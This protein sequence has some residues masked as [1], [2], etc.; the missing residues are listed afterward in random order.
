MS[1]GCAWV[2]MADT[3]MVDAILKQG[4]HT[5]GKAKVA[6]DSDDGLNLEMP[7]AP[8]MKQK[9]S[10]RIHKKTSKE[11]RQQEKKSPNYAEKLCAKWARY[12]YNCRHRCLQQMCVNNGL[13]AHGLS[14]QERVPAT[15]S[16]K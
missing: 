3:E 9:Q 5:V 14:L 10:T 15:D 1:R 13:Q 12:E 2:Y 11:R 4:V 6:R 7:S 16:R 8:H